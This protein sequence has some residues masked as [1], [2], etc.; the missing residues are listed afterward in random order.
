[1]R[2]ERSIRG[3]VLAGGKSS[4]MGTDKAVLVHPDGRSL[5]RRT[6]DLLREAGCVGVVLSLR[7]DQEIP[8]GMEDCE[9]VRDPEWG[10]GGPLTGMVAG[11]AGHP[12][13]DWLVV[14][15]DLPRLDAATLSHLVAS[16]GPEEKFLGY[17]SEFDDM[18]EP[19]CTWYSAAA[20][21]VLADAL[22]ADFRCPRK[23]LIRNHCRLL[24]PLVLRALENANTPEDWRKALTS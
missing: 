5:V 23:V 3:L 1:M 11:M 10:G 2:S 6:A 14:A 19:L 15:C 8:P 9:V 7:H 24:E 18:P 12:D 13:D 4:R 21:S 16:A 17:R 22:A 20:R